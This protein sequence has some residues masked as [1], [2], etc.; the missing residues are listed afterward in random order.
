[1]DFSKTVFA[2]DLDGT[3]LTSQKTLNPADAAALRRYAKMGGR[4]VAATGR[5]LHTFTDFLSEN[6]T[7]QPAILCNGGVIYDACQGKVL[8]EVD[9]PPAARE[10]LDD[11]RNAFPTI[12]PEIYTFPK[13]YYFQMNT[14]EKWHQSILKIDFVKVSSPDEIKEPWN[15]L[16]LADE[17]EV[18]SELMEYVRRFEGMGVRFVRSFPKFLE[19]LPEGVSKGSALK[20]LVEIMGWEGLKIAAAGDYDND[21]EMLEYADISFCPADSQDCVKKTV[22]HVLKNTCDSGAVAEALNILEHSNL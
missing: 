14:V 17:V 18:I 5:P 7:S 20:R 13:R 19:V 12:S 4:F 3:L 11:V 1:M 6:V 10:I 9:L 16:L 2:S 22:T 21:V 15:K 8:Y